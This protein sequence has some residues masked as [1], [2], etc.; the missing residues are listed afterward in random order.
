MF[1]L[2]QLALDL[3]SSW[4]D[5]VP[6]T[7]RKSFAFCWWISFLPAWCTEWVH[8]V[9][10]RGRGGGGKLGFRAHGLLAWFF[11]T[12]SCLFLVEFGNCCGRA[13]FCFPSWVDSQPP[14]QWSDLVI[15]CFRGKRG[16]SCCFS[17]GSIAK[18][19]S[20]EVEGMWSEHSTP[21]K[22]LTADLIM[23]GCTFL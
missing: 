13:L 12:H 16:K 8:R 1:L 15:V 7:V 2:H 19:S 10:V 22:N 6:W 18:F 17:V 9:S 3:T 21:W 4:A 5:S 14:Q 11:K 23:W 20:R